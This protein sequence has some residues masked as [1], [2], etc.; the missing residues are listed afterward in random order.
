[1]F[2]WKGMGEGVKNMILFDKASKYLEILIIRYYTFENT[3]GLPAKPYDTV[4]CNRK[5]ER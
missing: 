5:Q 1:M 4:V 2:Q 3:L